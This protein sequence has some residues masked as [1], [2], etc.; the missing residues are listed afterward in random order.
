MF[1]FSRVGIENSRGF[2][3]YSPQKHPNSRTIASFWSEFGQTLLGYAGL[4]DFRNASALLKVLSRAPFTFL[5]SSGLK[6]GRQTGIVFGQ[7]ERSISPYVSLL[8]LRDNLSDFH[9][10]ADIFV[11]TLADAAQC[12]LAEV[13]LEQVTRLQ[14]LQLFRILRIHD[15]FFLSIR[16]WRASPAHRCW[17]GP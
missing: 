2:V 1:V 3:F 10:N 15:C 14:P 13:D 9:S 17:W 8:V 6:I 5:L 11:V 12:S 16:V 4:G 7:G